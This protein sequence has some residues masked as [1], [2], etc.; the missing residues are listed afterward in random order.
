MTAW[1]VTAGKVELPSGMNAWAACHHQKRG[2]CGGCYARL[3]FAIDE[4]LAV[5][6]DGSM[7]DAKVRDGVFKVLK[8]AQAAMQ[9]EGPKAKRRAP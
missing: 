6:C 4:A 3:H 5:L 2:A 1:A 9:A 8:A 7:R